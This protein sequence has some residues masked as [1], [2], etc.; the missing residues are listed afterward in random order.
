M[1][2]VP[3]T[4]NAVL[5]RAVAG[6]VAVAK[7]EAVAATTAILAAPAANAIQGTFSPPANATR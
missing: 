6:I 7:D 4:V 2:H 1:L 5:M 3:P